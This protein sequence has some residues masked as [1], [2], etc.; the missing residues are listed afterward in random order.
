LNLRVLVLRSNQFHGSIDCLEDEKCGEQFSSLQIVDLASNN[1]S[2][3]LHPRWFENLKSMKKHNNTGQIIY[4]RN[5][6]SSSIT[7]AYKGSVLKFVKILTTLTAIDM[8]DNALEGSLPASIGNLVSLHVLNMSH[9]AFSG[10]IPPQLGYMTALESLDLSL[11]MLSGEIPQELTN[12]TF[13]STLNLSNNQLDGRIPQ[14]RQFGT[15]QNS[16]FDGNV[17]LCGTPLSKQCGTQD[18]QSETNMKSSSPSVDVVLFLFVGVGF[19]VGF[20]A[21]IL[22]KLNW[23]SKWF[24]NLRILL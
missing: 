15:F 13:L 6:T 17:G 9:N 3:N 22:V 10:E 5:L 16:S 21:A 2:G 12:L 20:A 19:G 23:I 14:S 1:F 11:N 24:H 8:S 4:H 18:T 7:I